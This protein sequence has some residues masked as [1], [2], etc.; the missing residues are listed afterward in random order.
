MSNSFWI[1]R[2]G[3]QFGQNTIDQFVQNGYGLKVS[4]IQKGWKTYENEGVSPWHMIGMI[5]IF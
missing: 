4:K 2:E 3:G 5:F 1:L